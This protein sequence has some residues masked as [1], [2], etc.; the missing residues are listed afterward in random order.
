MNQLNKWQTIVDELGEGTL[1]N[2]ENKLFGYYQDTL[3]DIKRQAQVYLDEYDAMSFAQRLEAERL[4]D[5]GEKINQILIDNNVKVIDTVKNGVREQAKNG[6]Y[7]TFYTL[8][9]AENLNLPISVL[10]EDYI[11]QLVNM[12]VN[13]K[14]L[15]KRLYQ[16][17]D[18]LAKAT[19]RSLLQGAIDG[20]GYAYVAKRIADL[21]E[22]DYRRALRIARTEG[23]RASSMATQ[24]G[25]EEVKKF[26]IDMKKQ[27]VSTLDGKT[28]DSHQ[29][30]DG[31]IAE[32]EDDFESPVTGAKGQG[33]RLMGRAS[34]DINCR[35][36]TI[37]VIDGISP[38]LRLDNETGEVIQNMTYNDWL[39]YKGVP[40][41]PPKLSTTPKV[42]QQIRRSHLTEMS[43]KDAKATIIN[44]LGVNHEGASKYYDNVLDYTG[45]DY[46]KLREYQRTGKGTA[47]IRTMDEYI[48]GYIEKA[49]KWDG[50]DIYRGV[51]MSDV[52]LR[53]LKIGTQ[54]NQGGTSSWSSDKDLAK[55][56]ANHAKD[57]AKRNKIIYVL[58][59]T[60][61]AT[62]ISHISQHANELEVL[63]SKKS[64]QTITKIRKQTGTTFIHLS[65]GG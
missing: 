8:E 22:A 16:N 45:S 51:S 15:S 53:Q 18:K 40:K 20:K 64:S 7:G 1:A 33:P 61:Q 32:I 21:T 49:P 39:N 11:E 31:Q 62:S 38:E 13:G 23:G 6:Y 9:G 19:T 28:R 25:Y 5:I 65:E 41:T 63:V 57:D 54:L 42:T 48:E 37:T 58:E 46:G 47:K 34:E 27:W 56:F 55:Y 44:E 2:T 17:T 52:E 43:E 29:D 12:P 50:G 26:G 30:M 14:T 36:T 60:D 4:L 3:R 35:C 59:K 10:G 24:K